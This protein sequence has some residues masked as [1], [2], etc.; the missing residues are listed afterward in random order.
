MVDEYEI[1]GMLREE[2]AEDPL[3]IGQ[4]RHC[5][6][7]SFWI[8]RDVHEGYVLAVRP[9]DGDGRP[10]WIALALTNLHPDHEHSREIKVQYYKSISTCHVDLETYLG[11]DSNQGNNWVKETESEPIWIVTDCIVTAWKPGFRGN[12]IALGSKFLKHN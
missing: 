12:S 4:R 11:W 10:F 6:P 9:A 1:D 3:F 8:G 5:P 2:F 7:P